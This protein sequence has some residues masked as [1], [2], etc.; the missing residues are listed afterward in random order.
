MILDTIG[1]TDNLGR[2]HATQYP[3]EHAKW[4][5]TFDH[6]A[7]VMIDQGDLITKH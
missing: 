2:L 7:Y 3:W 5:K 4:N 1:L 6:Q